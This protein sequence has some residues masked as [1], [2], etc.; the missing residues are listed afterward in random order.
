[1]P[2]TEG[3]GPVY[4]VS[5]FSTPPRSIRLFLVDGR[6]NGLRTAEIGLSTCKAVACPRTSLS[7]LQS[8]A[9]ARR[10][11]VYVLVG[12][13]SGR[14]AVYVGEGDVVMERIKRH[15]QEKDFW[16][17][18]ILFVSKDENLTKAHVRHLEAKLIAQALDAKQAT[19]INDREPEGGPLPEAD[20]AEMAQFLEQVQLLLGIFGV[21]VFERPSTSLAR[22]VPTKPMLTNPEIEPEPEP[23]SI[24]RLFARNC[25]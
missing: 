16:D 11:G 19:V 4:R 1:M 3:I 10:T 12:E 23:E 22:I 9:E 14:T 21:S 17:H 13:D 6:P 8:R 7:E 15:N 25:G 5:V 24:F 2:T 18:V 20:T